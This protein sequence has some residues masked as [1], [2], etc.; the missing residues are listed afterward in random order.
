MLHDDI[1]NNIIRKISRGER[2]QEKEI[3]LKIAE[4]YKD[5]MSRQYLDQESILLQSEMMTS[6]E[7]LLV[8]SAE[9]AAFKNGKSTIT[10]E[11]IDNLGNFLAINKG[12]FLTIMDGIKKNIKS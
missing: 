7:D 9:T 11:D 6:L 3:F 8:Y 10:L 12:I 1:I 5:V 2:N 4:I